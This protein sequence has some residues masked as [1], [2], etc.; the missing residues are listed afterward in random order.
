MLLVAVERTALHIFSLCICAISTRTMN[1]G[2]SPS[3][4][5]IKVPSFGIVFQKSRETPIQTLALLTKSQE[6]K[7]VAPLYS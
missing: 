1:E 5:V 6:S 2:P 4:R 3:K 7:L